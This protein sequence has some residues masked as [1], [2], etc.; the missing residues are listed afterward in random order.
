MSWRRFFSR[1]RADADLA[2]EIESYMAE[3]AAENR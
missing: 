2:E 1:K 3:E